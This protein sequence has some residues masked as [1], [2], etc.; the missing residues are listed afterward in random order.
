MSSVE[1]MRCPHTKLL[2]RFCIACGVYAFTGLHEYG[3]KTNRFYGI[4]NDI[5]LLK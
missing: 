3:V 4:I 5:S 1:V 2:N